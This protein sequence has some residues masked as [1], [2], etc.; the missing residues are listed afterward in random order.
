[1]VLLLL[2]ILLL[3]RSNCFKRWGF[4][5]DDIMNVE[6]VNEERRYFMRAA[7]VL[8]PV[9]EASTEDVVEA[10]GWNKVVR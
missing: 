1:M 9:P 6:I 2:K 10:V 5:P 8:R 3:S 4:G 7:L